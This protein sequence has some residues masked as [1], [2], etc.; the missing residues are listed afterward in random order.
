M[1]TDVGS[2]DWSELFE[3]CERYAARA[4]AQCPEL[5]VTYAGVG[6]SMYRRNHPSASVDIAFAFSTLHWCATAWVC[7]PRWL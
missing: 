1:H 2:N 7:A 3:S 6:G 5:H 4:Q